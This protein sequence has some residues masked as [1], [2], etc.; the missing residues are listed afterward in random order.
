MRKPGIPVTFHGDYFLFKKERNKNKTKVPSKKAGGLITQNE[1]RG[2]LTPGTTECR[3][4]DLK[5]WRSTVTT[6]SPLVLKGLEGRPSGSL[7]GKALIVFSN[8]PHC[9]VWAASCLGWA[10]SPLGRTSLRTLTD[11]LLW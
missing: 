5:R 1:R 4:A 8:H 11:P 10:R 6:H 3:P 9:G 7:R 2:I